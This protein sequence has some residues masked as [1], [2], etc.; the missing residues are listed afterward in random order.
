MQ[1]I[2][3]GH[4]GAIDVPDK[5]IK[6]AFTTSSHSIVFHCPI[7][8]ED[9]LIENITLEIAADTTDKKPI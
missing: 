3:P 8:E 7:C 6:D 5:D 9:V 2:C 4:N 1:I